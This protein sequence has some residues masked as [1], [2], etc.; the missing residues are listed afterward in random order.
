MFTPQQGHVDTTLTNVSVMYRNA[1][2][3]ADKVFLPLPVDKQ[4]NK[5]FVYGLDNLRSSIDSRRP[6]GLSRQINWS[7][8]TAPY[9]ADGHALHD[10]IPDESRENADAALDLDTDTTIALTDKLFLNREVALEAALVAA[11]SPTDLS[12]TGYANAW[13][14]V[15]IDPV[16]AIDKAKETVAKATGKKPN[17]MLMSRP[18][19]RAVRN[20]PL[21]K[22]RVSGA[23]QGVDRSLITVQQMAAL[24]EV[25]ELIIGD[26]INV[27]S[28]E[29]QTVTA[30]YIWNKDALL[31]YRPPSPGLRTIALGYQFTWNTGRMG[32]LVYRDRSNKRHADWI[33]VMRYYALQTV[34][35]AAGVMWTNATQN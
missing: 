5:Y 17:V 22:A 9:F 16:L 24:L 7:L 4:S 19:F 29:G 32:S 14:T 26:G 1:E 3:V 13:D 27:T 10:W 12:G 2:F 34:A 35:A 11:M 20:N 15:T 31:F 8:S 28:K 6:G 25:D 18:V 30:G 21:V 33:E 23:L